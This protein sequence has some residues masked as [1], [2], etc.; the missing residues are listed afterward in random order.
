MLKREKR[1]GIIFVAS[2]AADF[3]I[4]CHGIYSASKAFVD[5]FG[6]CLA[7]ENPHKIDVLSY[8]PNLVQ[9]NM[10]PL[11]SSF[12]VLKIKEAASSAL[13]KLGW[14]IETEGNWRHVLMNVPPKL[15]R[16]LLPQSVDMERQRR[17][18]TSLDK[19]VKA[20]E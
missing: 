18:I 1:S 10:V 17:Y 5:H 6:K 9:S 20:A 12:G 16:W 4:P 7:H 19:Q 15:T 8:K 14:D 2:I 13:D 3:I 11:E